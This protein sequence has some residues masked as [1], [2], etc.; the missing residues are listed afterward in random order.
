[1]H[2]PN[3]SN[4]YIEYVPFRCVQKETFTGI[5]T[6]ILMIRVQ[7]TNHLVLI[8]NCR[9]QHVLFSFLAFWHV[10]GNE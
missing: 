8:V 1:M 9:R 2:T 10:D 6:G 3:N 5:K 4:S 7:P